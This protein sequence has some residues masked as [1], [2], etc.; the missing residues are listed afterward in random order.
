MKKNHRGKGI[1]GKVHTGN[2]APKGGVSKPKGR[3]LFDRQRRA[4]LREEAARLELK[5]E[6]K[7][8]ITLR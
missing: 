6:L 8:K 4:I 5:Q 7:K 3:D 1:F 2:K